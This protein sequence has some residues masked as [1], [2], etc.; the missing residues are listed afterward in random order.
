MS[1]YKEIRIIYRVSD[2]E[3]E[4]NRELRGSWVVIGIEQWRENSLDG[5]SFTD[6][7]NYILGCKDDD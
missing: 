4:V 1:A 5:K 6:H 3:K 2:Y 7:T